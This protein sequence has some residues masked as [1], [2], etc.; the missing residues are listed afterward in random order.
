MSGELPPGIVNVQPQWMLNQTNVPPAVNQIMIQ[1][2]VNVGGSPTVLGEADG[3]YIT[4]GHVMPPISEPQAGEIVPIIPM[5]TYFLTKA[6]L[7]E[8]HSVIGNFLENFDG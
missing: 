8:F 4:F 6:R 2:G 5:G 1:G 7:A 3:L